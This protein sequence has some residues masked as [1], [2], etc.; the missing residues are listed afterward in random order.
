MNLMF[1]HI[2]AMGEAL[3]R[4]AAPM[5]FQSSVLMIMLLLADFVL[6]KKVRAVFRYWLWML[7]LVKLVLPSSMSSPVSVGCV[8]GD[9]LRYVSA[10]QLRTA[11]NSTLKAE[12][13]ENAAPVRLSAVE[14]FGEVTVAA[15]PPENVARGTA[16][17]LQPPATA[18]EVAAETAALSW[19]G[20]V[21]LAWLVVVVAMGL[22]LLQ[23]AFFVR[24]LVAQ[25]RQAKGLLVDSLEFCRR[26]M[27]VKTKIELKVSSS[28]TSPAV[29]GLF[30]PVILLPANLAP[31]LGSRH[32]RAVLMHE[33]A[34]IKRGDLWVNLLQ[35]LLQI[36]YFYNLLL[37]VANAVIRR[38][39]EQ[40]VDEMVLVAMGE[41]ARWYPE[42][43][44]SVAKLAFE[45]PVLSLRLIGV[46]ESKNAL[47]GRIKRILNRSIP[48]SAKLGFVGLVAILITAAI[49]LPM[50]MGDRET[51]A[52]Q[53]AEVIEKVIT[54]EH[55]AANVALN[56]RTGE[57]IKRSQA[58]KDAP[59]LSWSR[60]AG[61]G[62]EDDIGLLA[63]NM[64]LDTVRRGRKNKPQMDLWTVNDAASLPG[65]LFRASRWHTEF[66]GP[67]SVKWPYLAA[68]KGAD[69]TIG[70]LKVNKVEDSMVFV[71]YKLL[72]VPEQ[73]AERTKLSETEFK[74]RLSNGVTVEL[75]G[76]CEHP[77]EGKQWW[78][79]DGTMLA[80]RP[81]EKTEHTANLQNRLVREFATQFTYQGQ[82]PI[83]VEWDALKGQVD[84]FDK[85]FRSVSKTTHT[86]MSL[87]DFPETQGKCTVRVGVAAGPWQTQHEADHNELLAQSAEA[88]PPA[89]FAL[90]QSG[91]KNTPLRVRIDLNKDEDRYHRVQWQIVALDAKGNIHKSRARAGYTGSMTT[92]TY[93]A[94]FSNLRFEDLKNVRFQTRP[95]QWVEFKNVSLKPGVKSDV[96][97]EIE[98]TQAKAKV[99][100]TIYNLKLLHQKVIEFKLDSARYPTEEEGLCALT[101]QPSDVL[102]YPRGGYVKGADVLKDAWGNEFY[103][104]RYPEGGGDFR[105]VSWG[106]DGEEGG[107]GYN[108]DLYSTE[109]LRQDSDVGLSKTQG[110][111]HLAVLGGHQ[112]TAQMLLSQGFDVN[113]EDSEGN[114]PLH[115]AA[116]NGHLGLVG[117]LIERGANVNAVNNKGQTPLHLAAG[118]GHVAT[119]ELLIKSGAGK[120]VQTGSP[121]EGKER[122]VFLPDVDEEPMMLDLASGELVKVPQ[123]D[124]NP[125]QIWSAI[126]KL[127]KGDLVYDSKSLV[128]VRSATADVPLGTVTG[129]FY[130][131]KIGQ[132]LPEE[133]TVTTKEGRRYRVVIEQADDKGCKLRW[134]YA[135]SGQESQKRQ[136]R[137]GLQGLIDAAEAGSVVTLP[138]GV[139]TEPITIDKPLVLKGESAKDCILEVTSNGPAIFV[140]AGQKGKVVIEDITVKWQ[141]ATSER[142]ETPFAV[143]VQDCQAQVRKC[144]FYPLGNFK[145]CPVAI[146]S[147]GFSKLRIES[148][149]FEGFEY[150]VCFGEGSEGSIADSIVAGSGHQGI[151]LYSG[152]TAEITRNVVCNS[153]YHG[154]RSTGGT[155]DM[156]DN[157][158]MNNA[159]R[160]V[161]LGNKS[162]HGVVENNVIMGSGL[163][164]VSG[165][166][167]TDVKVR[168]NLI[169]DCG[170]VGVG[171]QPSCR[172]V[173][174]KNV[175]TGNPKGVVVFTK[176]SSSAYKAL[177]RGNTYWNNGVD[178]E[179]CRKGAGSLDLDPGLRS[180]E[181]GDFG[182]T[183]KHVLQKGHGLTDPAVFQSLWQ[184]SKVF[185][186]QRQAP[187]T[188]PDLEH[189]HAIPGLLEKAPASVGQTSEA[190]LVHNQLPKP[191][192]REL[193]Q[194]LKI[195][196]Q[197]DSWQE[198]VTQVSPDFAWGRRDM[199]WVGEDGKGMPVFTMDRAFVYQPEGSPPKWVLLERQLS[200]FDKWYRRLSSQYM[201]T[202]ARVYKQPPS[203]DVGWSSYAVVRSTGPK[204]ARVYEVC[205]PHIGSFG[206][207]NE[208]GA[209]LLYV[210]EDSEGKWRFIGK[211]PELKSGKLGYA[212]SYDRTASSNVTW[213]GQNDAPVRIDFTVMSTT[214]QWPTSDEPHIPAREEARYRRAVLAGEPPATLRWIS[215]WSTVENF[216]PAGSK[217]EFRVVPKV[218]ADRQPSLTE[219]EFGRCCEVLQSVGPEAGDENYRWFEIKDDVKGDLP[220]TEYKGKR[221]V[222]LC[223]Q[224]K[225]VMLPQQGWGL[226]KVDKG[227]D[228]L[229]RPMVKLLFDEKGAALFYK[230]TSSNISK[231]L[232]IAIDGKVVSAPT[233]M[234]AIRRAAVI[235]GTF[236]EEEI[237]QMVEALRKGMPPV[238]AEPESIAKAPN[239][240]REVYGV[241][242]GWFE[243]C[244][245]GGLDVIKRAY[246]SD[247]QLAERDLRQMREPSQM[248]PD[249]RFSLVSVMWDEQEAL[250]VSGA[251]K[252]GD[253]KVQGP[254]MLVWTLAKADRK[255]GITDIDLEEIEGLQRENSRFQQR[256]PDAQVWFEGPG[257]HTVLQKGKVQ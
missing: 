70:V 66:I 10:E 143:A 160:G 230:L 161:Y 142:S 135:G 223:S 145:R 180:P 42:T 255:W 205:W 184:K 232:A 219:T 125:Q 244:L 156:R 256:H 62:H 236:S 116:A 235:A 112:E 41:K 74:A 68:F 203:Q 148:C 172:L 77:S 206:S 53:G 163:V 175:I 128:R 253:P 27:G 139:Y 26:Q 247:Y 13:L 39:R 189:D 93:L 24:Q 6:R 220:V 103:Y 84:V 95:Y 57:F 21:F 151:S 2:N 121:D 20:L 207:S 252:L 134:R 28:A 249:W 214:R 107:E 97:I 113:A 81:Y 1:E 176:D 61:P 185:L 136:A 165:F 245:A 106:A 242:K 158:V 34:H 98:G 204:D 152:A 60:L 190:G 174:E 111:L 35:T 202:V 239:E 18:I 99:T 14:R 216:K 227:T 157:L 122:K 225:Y 48:K 120:Q 71:S 212:S 195:R 15:P 187:A 102:N 90:E 87:V 233:V 198:L 192:I 19:Q 44:V 104:E 117:F 146:K 22:L 231:P 141:L 251:L 36:V 43:L 229:G 72:S 56:L 86:Y 238:D 127:G 164:G 132:V 149:L 228:N 16:E 179:N 82:E 67:T 221:Y 215:D 131:Y 65:F 51:D 126:E 108:Q 159:N 133:I 194:R 218:G 73:D 96:K 45:R 167:Q 217:L 226:A 240:V 4:F 178:T 30:R 173:L 196:A 210:L 123:A 110:P 171:L 101:E 33:L 168:N 47:K 130:R 186:E 144:R 38:V 208:Q 7:V 169:M 213:T 109:V 83:G 94:E 188:N 40:A 191:I 211:G 37:W 241:L 50:A 17:H 124:T 85:T 224:P 222:L 137:E 140:K 118:N 243:G 32:L 12:P 153:R 209:T 119:A 91:D 31:S 237:E 129:N 181:A 155:L 199:M 162:A 147:L 89:T 64:K 88:A 193:G 100:R 197:A 246:S 23:R 59:L 78:Q 3:V 9:K 29:C 75:I 5:L 46:V 63:W 182:I 80:T 166:A 183:N 257:P 105:I 92:R 8:I 52:S 248:N 200:P 150:T 79:P 115:I 49:L 250:A 170:E 69:G 25:A 177:V 138:A 154:V 11:E 234:T 55:D 201:H 114:T 254:Q 54:P 58:A 76:V